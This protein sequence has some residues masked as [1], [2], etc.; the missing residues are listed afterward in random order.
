MQCASWFPPAKLQ[1]DFWQSWLQY[2]TFMQLSGRRFMSMGDRVSWRVTRNRDAGQGQCTRE[3]RGQG[4]ATFKCSP[5]ALHEHRRDTDLP[6]RL[7][8]AP[9]PAWFQHIANVASR[10][11]SVISRCLRRRVD[12]RPY[13]WPTPIVTRYHHLEVGG[14]EVGG[15]DLLETVR[16]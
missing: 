3:G 10:V 16:A 7:V 12:V 15:P 13:Q 11:A 14:L 6:T 8:S 2:M 9:F 4:R 1:C 5:A